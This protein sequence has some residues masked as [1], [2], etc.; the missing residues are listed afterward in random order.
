MPIV[1]LQ[2]TGDR[3]CLVVPGRGRED[4]AVRKVPRVSPRL[5]IEPRK[6]KL[7]KA[8]LACRRILGLFYLSIVSS[9]LFYTVVTW[10][11]SGTCGDT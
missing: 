1:V 8:S 6:K 7:V 3:I 10:R 9:V 4:G 5:E 2:E 11:G